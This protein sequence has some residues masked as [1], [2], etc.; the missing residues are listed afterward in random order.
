MDDAEASEPPPKVQRV[1]PT[2]G[3]PF[4]CLSNPPC[5]RVFRTEHNR[6]THKCTSGTPMQDVVL[7]PVAG[8]KPKPP[9]GTDWL[10]DLYACPEGCGTKPKSLPFMRKHYEEVHLKLL[11]YPCRADPECE[12]RFTTSK[13]RNLHEDAVHKGIKKYTCPTCVPTSFFG[14]R[15]NLVRH[16][17]NQHGE[18]PPPG[19]AGALDCAV[20]LGELK[21]EAME[22]AE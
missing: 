17:M 20:D 16:C 1:E 13:A 6:R 3:F 12:K 5:T 22:P 18:R 10:P 8:P 11:N 9:K 15:S 19:A 7:L 4:P 21:E 2:G 14:N